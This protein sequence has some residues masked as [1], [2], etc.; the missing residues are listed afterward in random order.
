MFARRHP[1]LF[2]L[3]IVCGCMTLGFLGVV[4]LVVLGSS[5]VDTGLGDMGMGQ[6][7]NIGIVEVTVYLKPCIT[8]F[9]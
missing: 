4:S 1:F 9:L 2:F 6:D 5:M 3:S 8:C 7:G